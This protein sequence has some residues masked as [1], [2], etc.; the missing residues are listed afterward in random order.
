MA[1]GRNPGAVRK[2]TRRKPL[3]KH[4]GSLM[5]VDFA[6]N[7]EAAL[8]VLEAKVAQHVLRSA[9]YAGAKTVYWAMRTE[10]PVVTGE[11]F[12]AVYHWFDEK[13]AKPNTV[14][15]WIGPNKKKAPQWWNVEYGHWRYNRYSSDPGGGWLRSK[16]QSSAKLAEPNQN[17]E[18]VHD[19]ASGRLSTPQWVPGN[20][21][22]RR[23]WDKSYRMALD[24]AKRR[25]SER[26]R[27][28]LREANS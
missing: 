15:Y 1:N 23:A 22:I 18:S 25:F 27:E 12:D 10:V 28:V 24:A 7:I 14:Q 4:P 9:T 8:R 26:F 21:Y 16:S 11:L 6:T 5:Q 20:P 17:V 13:N 19:I 3:Q 2:G